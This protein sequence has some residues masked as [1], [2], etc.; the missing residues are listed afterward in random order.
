MLLI[1]LQMVNFNFITIIFFQS[2][3]GDFTF[4][5]VY[6]FCSILFTI[7]FFNENYILL[8]LII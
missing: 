8:V 6:I 4:L 7:V 5:A 1:S 3:S 2:L